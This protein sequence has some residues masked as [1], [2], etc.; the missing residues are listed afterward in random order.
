MVKGGF[1]GQH[2]VGEY[3]DGPDIDKVVVGLSLEYF[4]ADVV[5][6]AAV[7]VAPF[8]AVGGPAEV[9]QFANALG[10]GRGTL[11]STMFYGLMSRWRMSFAC[12]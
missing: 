6:G 7:G 4:G 2:L 3:S 12:R 10:E 8:L 9:A 11:V 1:A 5:E